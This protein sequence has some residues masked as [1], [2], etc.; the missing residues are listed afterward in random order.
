M[1]HIT[2][3]LFL[4]SICL[5]ATLCAA[6]PRYLAVPLEDL[7][8]EESGYNPI[9]VTPDGRVIHDQQFAGSR[10]GSAYLPQPL[11][12]GTNHGDVYDEAESAR[13]GRGAH[14]HG[15]IVDYGA[16]TGGHGAFG[17]YTDHPVHGHH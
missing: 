1:N 3:Q 6:Y 14:H 7:A 16:Y 2:P 17:W 13:V 4:A 11:A 5:A 10:S 15:D 8:E 12:M 9:I